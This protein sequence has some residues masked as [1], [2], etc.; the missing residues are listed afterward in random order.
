ME[1][2]YR[3][4]SPTVETATHQAVLLFHRGHEHSG[5]WQDFVERLELDDKWIFAW[6]A[7]GHGGSP[8][9]RG[10]AESLARMVQ[11]ADEWARHVSSTFDVPLNNMGVVGQSVGAVL[12]ATW[13]HDYAPPVRALVLATPAFRIKL[14]VPGAIP[15]L[16]LLNRLRRPYFIRSY[17][18]PHML[19]HDPEQ[20]R[21]YADDRL[22]SPQIAVNI[23]L[24]LHDTSSR[25]I[26]DAGAIQTPTLLLI[27]GRDHVVQR[28]PQMQFFERLSS[29]VKELEVYRDFLH[30][31]YWEQDRDRPI[32]RTR[33]FLQAA[34]ARHA[35]L[36]SLRNADQ[37][38]Y[39][40]DVFDRLQ[41]PVAPLSLKRVSY[42]LQSLGLRTLGR[43][44]K[45]I[46]EGW[47]TGFDSGQS[48]DH[49]YRNVAEGV[50][51]LGRLIDRCYLDTPGWRGIRQR[52]VHLQRLL[53][54]AI[55]EMASRG[56]RV[57]LFDV[58]AGPG[59]YV[60]ET[61]QRR[62]DVPISAVLG[63]RDAGGLQAGR[64]L[65][66]QMGIET[67]E[68]RQ[69]DAFD[70]EALAVV[71]PRPNLAVVSGLF[72][73]F[74]ENARVTAAL[75]GLARAVE[76]GGYLIYTNQPSHPQQE[77]IARIL[78]NRDG[79]PWVMRCR[80][81]AEMDQ[82]VEAAGFR[83]MEQLIDETGIFSVSLAVRC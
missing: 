53:D 20:A 35:P 54:R 14:Y 2:C 42:S 64:R 12:A 8:G 43:L 70:G 55:D 24:D 1:L 80:T 73:L 36:P 39:T 67:V 68:Y 22:V 30:S 83:K 28:R 26:E 69:H 18:N 82:L 52:K 5:R 7:R 65:A 50:T 59:R 34:F 79:D 45:G 57:Q 38:G 60:L 75:R 58:A 72:E 74:P 77:L 56:E 21:L 40:R 46:Q 10:Y 61:I 4:W 9:P 11:D 44:S 78:P 27:S 63:D 6:D 32:A 3:V 16:R 19:T 31:T 47:R 81:Q 17:V 76:P 48:L 15:G 23:L 25:L 62:S 49:V 29:S 51:P 13:V 66:E 33:K 71:S 37:V 41:Q